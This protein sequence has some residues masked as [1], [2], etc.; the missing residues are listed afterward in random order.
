M[1]YINTWSIKMLK[2]KFPNYKVTSYCPSGSWQ[3]S[4]YMQ[5]H[6]D[7][8]NDKICIMNIELMVIGKAELSC[9]LKVIGKRNT[10]F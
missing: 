7:A 1:L 5:I 10:D 6:I 4:R 2:Q 3:T 9:I 8:Y